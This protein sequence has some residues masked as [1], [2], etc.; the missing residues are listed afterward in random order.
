MGY[1]NAKETG[2]SALWK[3]LMVGPVWAD[4][5]CDPDF[6]P[7]MY[8]SEVTLLMSKVDKYIGVALD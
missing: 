7:A 2:P 4:S 5:I 3:H 1:E 6:S 8:K